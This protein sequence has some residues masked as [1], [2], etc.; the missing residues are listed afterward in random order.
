MM[1]AIETGQTLISKFVLMIDS[2]VVYIAN[3]MSTLAV[4]ANAL[5]SHVSKS[6]LRG[7][8]RSPH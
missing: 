7:K 8:T 6:C 3:D 2:T 4:L 1:S 5:C